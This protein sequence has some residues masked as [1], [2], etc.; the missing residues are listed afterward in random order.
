MTVLEAQPQATSETSDPKPI[1]LCLDC[2]YPLWGLPTP[3]CPECG[4]EFDPLDPSTMIMGRA[5][6]PVARWAL[7]PLR[8]HVNLLSWLAIG[9]A[10]WMARLPGGQIRN[11]SSL[12]ILILLG[13]FWVAWPVLRV[14]IAKR[15]GWPHSLVMRGQKT[16]V[17]VGLALLLSA[18][19]VW[20]DLPLKASLYVSRP[21]M[22]KLATE[23][24]ASSEPYADDQWLGV[25]KAT[26][27]KKLVGVKGVRIT[28]EESNR[29][30]RS[31]F[32]YLPNVDASRSTWRNKN[33]HHVSG[34]WWAWREEG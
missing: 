24:L 1:G 22:D 11:S 33:Y 4:R 16:R 8:W 34:F 10:L 6:T 21:A 18:A 19:A 3:R 7:G 23:L 32:V 5:L 28:C 30:Y 31:G 26:R 14:I 20:Y 15:R 9:Y 13:L 17:V 29:A 25:Y 27:I 2:N 12:V